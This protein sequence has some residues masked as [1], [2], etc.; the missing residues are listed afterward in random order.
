MLRSLDGPL[1]EDLP[2]IKAPS[3]E[4]AFPCMDFLE[5]IWYNSDILYI[6]R[7]GVIA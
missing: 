1:L 4:G 7:R 5:D 3:L 6:T 2:P